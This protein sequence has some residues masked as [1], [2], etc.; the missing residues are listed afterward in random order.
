MALRGIL[1]STVY[2]RI[3]K[4]EFQ[5]RHI[6]SGREV[7]TRSQVP[8]TTQRLLVGDFVAAVDCLRQSLRDVRY[9]PRFLAAPTVVMHPLE[10]NEG[11]LSAIE[12]RALLELAEGAGGKIAMVWEGRELADSEVKEHA[13]AA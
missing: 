9:G 4:N 1:T 8:F 10:M 3:R 11:G 6:E 5:V 13:R 12:R 2:V 7:R